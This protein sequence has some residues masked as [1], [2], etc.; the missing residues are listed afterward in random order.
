MIVQRLRSLLFDLLFYPLTFIILTTGSLFFWGPRWMSGWVYPM[1]S[2]VT[3]F[4]LQIIVGLNHRAEGLENVLDGPVIFA[5]KHQSAWD[6]FIFGQ[7]LRGPAI[8]YKK[9][10]QCLLPLGF[11]LIHQKMIPVSRGKGKIALKEM[12]EASRLAV[13]QSRPILVFP[14]GKRHPPGANTKYQSGIGVLYQM[15]G[16]PVVPVA[17]NSGHFWGRR[18]FFKKPG[19]IVLRFLPPIA[20]GL[21]RAQF[22][23]ALETSIEGACQDIEKGL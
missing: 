21:P 12:I 11:I 14:E 13:A 6:T 7:Y 18:S 17:L 23:H 19:T 15:L 9:D 22:L 10:L 4:L 3:T 2:Y 20:P 16:I 1:H 5:A 8:I